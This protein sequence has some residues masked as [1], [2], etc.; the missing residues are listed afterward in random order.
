MPS[1]YNDGTLKLYTSHLTP[2]IEPGGQPEYH[3]K[4][5]KAW[6]VTSDV[7]TFRHG[8]TAFR[9]ARDFAKEMR[10][11][12][13]EAANGRGGE[14]HTTSESFESSPLWGGVWLNSQAR[15]DGL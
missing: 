6:A 2:P 5:L 10:D 4:Q 14:A 13:I 9:S 3:L 1:I 8:A 15:R 7:E 11:E 12:S